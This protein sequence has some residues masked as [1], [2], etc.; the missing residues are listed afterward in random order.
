MKRGEIGR[1]GDVVYWLDK[2]GRLWYRFVWA[3]EWALVAE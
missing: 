2:K 1:Q 3:C